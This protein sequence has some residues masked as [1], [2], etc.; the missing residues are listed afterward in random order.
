MQKD[1]PAPE[2]TINI[3]MSFRGLGGVPAPI[4][5][6]LQ[7]F[8]GGFDAAAKRSHR[9]L[10]HG[11]AAG[12][13][14]SSSGGADL[15][16]QGNDD[17]EKQA[18]E[19]VESLP[20]L[21]QR[22]DPEDARFSELR[23]VSRDVVQWHIADSAS[24]WA[25]STDDMI[26]VVE[27]A[28]PHATGDGGSTTGGTIANDNTASSS[29]HRSFLSS[30]LSS[31]AKDGGNAP[32]AT[33][34]AASH[35][36]TK[37]DGQKTTDASITSAFRNP[38]TA[39]VHR[40]IKRPNAMGAAAGCAG[41]AAHNATRRSQSPPP[42]LP[43]LR[44][45]AGLNIIATLGLN[46]ACQWV[47]TLNI[48]VVRTLHVRRSAKEHHGLPND[49]SGY[50]P[51][52]IAIRHVTKRVYGSPWRSRVRDQRGDDRRDSVDYPNICFNLEDFD[53]NAFR[54]PP[55]H[56]LAV[57]VTVGD[58]LDAEAAVFRGAVGHG[59]IAA[60]LVTK[61]KALGD[62]HVLNSIHYIPLK[63]SS[64]RAEVAVQPERQNGQIYSP[65]VV[66][67][68]SGGRSTP[69]PLA[70]GVD[71]STDGTRRA[72]SA[73]PGRTATSTDSVASPTVGMSSPSGKQPASGGFFSRVSSFFSSP[74]PSSSRGDFAS[75]PA[76]VA[77][78]EVL[79]CSL[80]GMSVTL[81]RVLATL[82]RCREAAH[83][84]ELQCR[85]ARELG[86]PGPPAPPPSRFC[87]IPESDQELQ[88]WKT[89]DA[90]WSAEHR[91]AQSVPSAAAA[92][93]RKQPH[94]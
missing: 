74:G 31:K 51:E 68:A 17:R 13:H 42:E 50:V 71:G 56:Q 57:L 37:V 83:A 94:R 29:S 88:R 79:L 49:G 34:P 86:Q 73:A 2:G 75:P 72:A 30:L 81:D 12:R 92:P 41:D 22:D 67:A 9:H 39:A 65:V 84:W 35:S 77:G 78:S 90:L 91:R 18:A 61:A 66:S 69:P 40:R 10:V 36:S 5:D 54:L 28:V 4:V 82:L 45:R 7:V 53:T 85:H 76:K 87:R 25:H 21:M 70:V 3:P 38:A 8:G 14:H 63:A 1:S 33:P 60:S 44:P 48:S 15:R 19:L 11:E 47:Y 27:N 58:S 23:D 89:D 6:A 20:H 59:S 24:P 43:A 32:K 62:E 80:T 52:A 55:D 46:L 64:G 16:C 26:W 93:S